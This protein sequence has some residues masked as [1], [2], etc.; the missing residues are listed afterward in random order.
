[1]EKRSYT[2]TLQLTEEEARTLL[3]TAAKREQGIGE[4]LSEIV[5]YIHSGRGDEGDLLEDYL[6]RSEPVGAGIRT[7]GDLADM[8]KDEVS[9]IRNLGKKS[10]REITMKLHEQGLEFRTAK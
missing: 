6:Q 7:L 2:V 10:L 5:S 8:T 9:K 3:D 1:M 4:F